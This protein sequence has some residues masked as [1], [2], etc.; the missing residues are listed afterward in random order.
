MTPRNT[1]SFL[2]CFLLNLI[3]L[4]RIQLHGT[5]NSTFL[6]VSSRALVHL[7]PHQLLTLQQN[8]SHLEMSQ[9]KFLIEKLP[10]LNVWGHR[11]L[12]EGSWKFGNWVMEKMKSGWTLN[13][14]KWSSCLVWV[15]LV[16]GNIFL[17]FYESFSLDTSGPHCALEPFFITKEIREAALTN[18]WLQ[19]WH[20]GNSSHLGGGGTWVLLMV[21]C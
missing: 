10:C 5:R 16:G 13:P 7:I 21:W 2:S 15:C 18:L 11:I 8:H 6:L 3:S 4:G 1:I 19:V 14:D 12:K 20:N 9:R 17:R